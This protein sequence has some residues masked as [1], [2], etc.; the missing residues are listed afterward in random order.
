MLTIECLDEVPEDFLSECPEGGR[1]Y[2]AYGRAGVPGF[3]LGCFAVRRNGAL[4]SIAPFFVMDIPLNTMMPAGILKK[5]MGGLSLKIAFI[6][7]PSADFGHIQGE[8]TPEVL[9]RINEELFK[10]ASLISYKG[11]D[12]NLDLQGFKKVAGLPVPILAVR[13]DYWDKLKHKV[14]TDLK[15]K[16]KASRNLELLEV[17]GLP[18]AYL[19]RVHELYRQTCARSDIQFEN[20]NIGYFAETASISKYILYFEGGT[21]IGF[22]QLMCNQDSM[23]CKYIGMDYAKSL[24]YKLYFALMLESINICI[25]DGIRHMDFGVTSYAFKKYV[26]SEMHETFNYFRH[27]W[28]LVNLMLKRASFLLEPSAS[29]LQ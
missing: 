3:T 11:F 6:G 2:R 27:R 18:E 24:E 17:D 25:R 29:E 1:F 5:L 23:Y 21:L 19:H 22:Q 10:Y 8:R 4:I 20:L 26:G 28:S 9:G 14:R 13:P 12:G 16:L 7:H 15:R